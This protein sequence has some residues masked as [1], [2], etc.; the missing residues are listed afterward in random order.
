MAKTVC[1][2]RSPDWPCP[3]PGDFDDPNDFQRAY[4]KWLAEGRQ[5]ATEDRI[6]EYPWVLRWWARLWLS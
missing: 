1:I 4:E 5:L 6:R 3:L 2:W